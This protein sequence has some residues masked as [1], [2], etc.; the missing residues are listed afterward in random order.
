M[1][2]TEQTMDGTQS[3]IVQHSVQMTATCAQ[4]CLDEVET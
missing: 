3:N 2:L 4:K 1:Y